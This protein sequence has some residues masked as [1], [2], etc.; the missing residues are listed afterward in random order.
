[1]SWEQ[2]EVSRFTPA[3]QF[4]QRVAALVGDEQHPSISTI[5][6]LALADQDDFLAT[7]G[8]G[9]VTH[10]RMELRHP[11]LPAGVHFE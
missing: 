2:R 4:N 9:R 3:S 6:R 7:D 11:P 8:V 5:A 1:L 10:C